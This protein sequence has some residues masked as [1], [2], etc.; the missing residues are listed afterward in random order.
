MIGFH[1]YWPGVIRTFI[2]FQVLCD[3][4]DSNENGV[5]DGRQSPPLM[6]RIL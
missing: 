4:I 2:Y 5:S 1:M 3:I 6:M